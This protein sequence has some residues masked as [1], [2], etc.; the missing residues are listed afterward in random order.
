MSFIE[1]ARR[2][3]IIECAID[4][5]AELGY[6]Q[7]S[8]AQIASRA[9][10]AKGVISY[11]FDGKDDLIRHVA[12]AVAV[13]GLAFIQPR[14]QA[15]DTARGKLQAFIESSIDYIRSNPT[16]LAAL[17]EIITNFRTKDGKLQIDMNAGKP[18][19][20]A[21]EAILQTGQENG[22][23]RGDF[24]INVM[25]ITIQGSVNGVLGQWVAHA[26]LDLEACGRELI[27]TFDLATR[28]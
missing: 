9:G 16:M 6:A 23:F 22:E 18:L 4:V 19:L 14:V 25:A 28:T 3:Q 27:R 24:A 17:I 2:A 11:Y 8:L 21:L 15:Q 7:A 12:G 1:A 5:I 10:I 13:S 20:A 26:D